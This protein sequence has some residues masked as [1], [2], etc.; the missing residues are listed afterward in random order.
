MLFG[1]RG[2]VDVLCVG[3]GLVAVGI[4]GFFPTISFVLIATGVVVIVLA[5][6]LRSW[7]PHQARKAATVLKQQVDE[8]SGDELPK[9]QSLQRAREVYLKKATDCLSSAEHNL[10]LREWE[11]AH[12]WA[13][14]GSQWIKDYNRLVGEHS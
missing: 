8:L 13:G 2:W 14:R 3:L 1:T 7:V 5:L 6:A 12:S 10:R 9:S 11:R 4:I